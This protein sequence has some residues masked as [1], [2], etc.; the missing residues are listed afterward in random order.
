MNKMR[1]L[2]VTKRILFFIGLP[3]LYV[4]CH[5]EILAFPEKDDDR[6]IVELAAS[7]SEKTKVSNDEFQ[8]GDQIGLFMVD[9]EGNS[10]L[11]LY[12]DGNHADNIRFTYKGNPD[13]WEADVPIYWKGDNAKAVFYGYYPYSAHIDDP[14][15]FQHKVSDNQSLSSS[16]SYGLGG[17][18][19]SDFLWAKTA[20]V[21]SKDGKVNLQFSHLMSSIEVR[22]NK[23]QGF[24]LEEW[25]LARKQV[26]VENTVLSS[27]IDLASGDVQVDGVEI[28]PISACKYSDSFRAVVVPQTIPSGVAAI[29]ILINDQSYSLV[30]NEDVVLLQNKKHI[31]TITVDKHESTG[32]YSFVLDESVVVPW[33]DEGE[34]RDGIT[35][36]YTVVSVSGPG[37]LEKTVLDS[38][39][40][41][42]KTQNLKVIG[43][44]N[45]E[46]CNFISESFPNLVCVN[47]SEVRIK[48]NRA[49]EHNDMKVT[50]EREL[51]NLLYNLS[52]NDDVLPENMFAGKKKMKKFYFPKILKGIADNCFNGNE[53]S[54]DITIP[55][56]VE[57]IGCWAF[58]NTMVAGQL[59]LPSTLKYIGGNAFG[60][61]NRFY[62][63]G[64][65]GELK[66][67]DGL[68]A[69]GE[70][71]F[72]GHGNNFHRFSGYLVLPNTLSYVGEKALEYCRFNGDLR[73][74]GSLS[75]IPKR[76]FRGCSFDGHLV[77]EEGVRQIGAQSF[78]DCSFFGELV[79]PPSLLTIG[80]SAFRN[81]KITNILFNDELLVIGA[82]AFQRTR[83]TELNLPETV[84]TIME[85]SFANCDMLSEIVLHKDVSLI[86]KNAF[87]GCHQLSR[88]VCNALVPPVTDEGAFNNMP[89]ANLIVEVPS[90]SLTLYKNNADW[91]EFQ[92]ILQY[93][94]FVCRPDAVCALNSLLSQDLILNAD[95][96]WIVEYLPDWCHLSAD[97]GSSKSSVMLTVS[98]LSHG[99]MSREDKIIFR[100]RDTDVTAECRVVQYDYQYNEDECVT[101]QKA[102]LGDGS[103][104]LIFVGDGYDAS[105]LVDGT[106]MDLVR[107][108]MEYFFGIFP[109]NKLRDYFNVY[110]LVSLS[111]ESGIN[112]IHTWRDTKFMTTYSI[113]TGMPAVDGNNV[114]EYI[115][116]NSPVRSDD[117]SS[118]IVILLPNAPEYN[119]VT[120]IYENGR[121]ISI[122]PHTSRSYPQDMRGVVQHEACGHGFG[123]LADETVRYNLFA[124]DAVVTEIG[125]MHERAWGQN[126]S[127]SGKFGEVPW[128][129]MIF[130]SRY[131]NDVDVYE[132]GFGYSRGVFRSEIN[133]CMNYGIPYFNAI[134]R[135]DIVRRI[136]TYAG[137]EYSDEYFYEIDSKEWGLA[138]KVASP[139]ADNLI[140]LAN[141]GHHRTPIMICTDN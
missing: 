79:L 83:I 126:L 58:A 97:S 116:D 25:S 112:T 139:S 87:N 9:Y 129:D 14:N 59:N 35:R 8:I 34:F 16:S 102:A 67:P 13:S 51:N 101:L 57:F 30:K 55:E 61:V 27:I 50:S 39:I 120:Q 133:S 121:A 10:P 44:L 47:F 6:D 100:L 48:G 40:N 46:D 53:L 86:Q 92:R 2:E 43:V 98:E 65:S 91:K 85:E 17:Y 12:T 21:T 71:S 38:G 78:E 103:V 77:I 66:L 138:T 127:V 32:D 73:I 128:S 117:L 19:A 89:K 106:Y 137:E 5:D 28:A 69:I 115:V 54:G 7:L 119:A 1:V 56:G 124:P 93:S 31:F 136:L 80:E 94:G 75:S 107:E 20:D 11:P 41:P 18:E 108:Q 63:P 82:K 70:N 88:F 36:A 26:F 110:A 72:S 22:L 37:Q 84:T 29:S 23:G 132:G 3:T 111:Q 141:S 95:G 76:A 113:D 123:K 118:S 122:C 114:F 62:A 130:D 134:S 104:N 15:A 105:S 49:F 81:T 140:P 24:E 4:A 52:T 131:S 74:P 90:Q 33:V 109:F 125:R 42:E 96:P 64:L 60:F 45:H 135:R 68:I 99:G